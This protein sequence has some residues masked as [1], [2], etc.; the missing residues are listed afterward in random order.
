MNGL[1]FVTGAAG[2]IGSHL[3]ERLVE[4]GES[5]RGF[6]NL[7]TGRMDNLARAV[8]RSNFEFTRGDC[9][10][11]GEVLKALAGVR[12]VFHLAADPEVRRGVNDPQ[13]QFRQNV[14]ATQLLLE[15]V[16]RVGSLDTF[17]LASTSTVYGNATKL[18]TPE[19]YGPLCPIS[20]Y[21][22]T[23]LAC[24]ALC[25]SYA[26]SYGFRA[27]ILRLANIVGPRS[28]HGVIYDFVAKIK[29]NPNR[30]E[31]LGDG[32]QTKSYLY[33]SDCIDAIVTAW[34]KSPE[35]VNVFNVGSN[36]C[37]DVA[38]IADIV[39]R[40]VNAKARVEFVGGTST[41]AGWVGDVK[42]MWLD[43]SRLR[44]LG[45]HPRLNSLESVSAAIREF[46]GQPDDSRD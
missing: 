12:H 44:A 20:T 6:D 38:K 30:L 33:V 5:V 15:Q 40:Q 29:A 9:L 46:L 3:A 34:K 13:S 17:V 31:V 37:V 21:G 11:H 27:I 28:S 45:W 7:S 25:S 8:E 32:T 1:I 4:M 41:G 10:N 24:E 36:D 35:G 18:P 16:R 23:K 2:F 39:I 43:I 19:D 22:A 42:K 14:L 26:S